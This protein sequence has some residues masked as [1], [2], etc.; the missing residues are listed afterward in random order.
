[1]TTYYIDPSAGVNGNGLSEATPLN[2]WVGLTWV[3]GNTYLQK[4]GTAYTG[5]PTL[6]TA[7][8]TLGKYGVGARPKHVVSGS[9]WSVTSTNFTIKDFEI[10]SA[11]GGLLVGGTGF[12]GDNL[13]IH[14]CLS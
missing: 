5:I 10:T 9:Y 11:D 1:M 14:D 2:T 7:N 6:T 13:D 12:L 4:A 3:D 8:I